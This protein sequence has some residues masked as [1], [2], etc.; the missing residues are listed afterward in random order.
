[1]ATPIR[2]QDRSGKSLWVAEGE[3][4]DH[5]D[6]HLDFRRVDPNGEVINAGHLDVDLGH[7]RSFRQVLLQILHQAEVTPP[8]RAWTLDEKQAQNPNAYKRWTDEER[9]Q[10]LDRFDAGMADA[11]IAKLHGRKRTSIRSELFKAGRIPG[12]HLS[13]GEEDI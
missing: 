11:E 12:W 13:E 6:V 1:M 4:D 10:V 5:N 8:V 7:L 9:Q 3:V 2:Y